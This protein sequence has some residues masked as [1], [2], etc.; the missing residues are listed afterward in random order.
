MT[1][2]RVLVIDVF[3]DRSE[4]TW[5]ACNMNPGRT[6]T[7]NVEDAQIFDTFQEAEKMAERLRDYARRAIV[8]IYEEDDNAEAN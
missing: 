7:A 2:Y 5:Y 6:L 4:L 3:M 1:K 8:E